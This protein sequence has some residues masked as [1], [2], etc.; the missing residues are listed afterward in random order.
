MMAGHPALHQADRSIRAQGASLPLPHQ[1]VARL[2]LQRPA[3]S[4]K[5]VHADCFCPLLNSADVG[6]I[7]PGSFGKLDLSEPCR[8]PRLAE[9]DFYWSHI[10]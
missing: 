9:P 6:L 2:A 8:L 5:D 7:H 1:D 10:E 3:E 4:I